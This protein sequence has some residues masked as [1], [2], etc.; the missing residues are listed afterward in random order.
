MRA[1]YNELRLAGFRVWIDDHLTPGTPDWQQ[2]IKKSLNASACVVCICSPNTPKSRWVN[3]ELSLAEQNGLRRYPVLVEGTARTS[4]PISLTTVQY[5]DL[6]GR[7]VQESSKLITA[8]TDHHRDTLMADMRS[9]FAPTGIRWIYCASLFWFASEVRKMRLFLAPERPTTAR[10]NDSLA[11]LL[12]HAKRL[13]ADT[14]TIREIKRIT[15]KLAGTGL[16]KLSSR[17]RDFLENKLR[18]T[19]DNIENQAEKVDVSFKIGPHPA[20]P[21]P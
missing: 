15:K 1:V 5:S 4:I 10:L 20:R 21:N 9:I 12:H 3:I 16:S 19:Q 18:L 6:K 11:Q 17:D 2:A 14:F 8:L 7:Y 13:N